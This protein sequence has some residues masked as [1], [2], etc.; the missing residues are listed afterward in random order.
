M[1]APLR[2]SI[3]GVSVEALGSGVRSW[4]LLEILGELQ[5]SRGFGRRA[6][7]WILPAH[8]ASS[9]VKARES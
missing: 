5:S 4:R 9:C 3:R 1:K 7:A 6:Q 8:F 2:V